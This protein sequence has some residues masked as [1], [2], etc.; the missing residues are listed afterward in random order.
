V[1]LKKAIIS[2]K[3]FAH[4]LLDFCYPNFK[5]LTQEAK[6]AEKLKLISQIKVGSAKFR[7]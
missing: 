4:T 3:I 1:T 6:Q 7:I 2:K 5:L